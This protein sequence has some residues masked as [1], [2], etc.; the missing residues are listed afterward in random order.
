METLRQRAVTISDDDLAGHVHVLGQSGM[1]KSTLIEQIALQRAWQGRGFCFIDPHGQSAEHILDRIPPVR[2]K[3]ILY[4]N[5]ANDAY[6]VGLNILEKPKNPNDRGVVASEV[7]RMFHG[8]FADSWG[9]RLEQVLRNT[10][11]ALLEQEQATLLSIRRMLVNEPYRQHVLRRVRNH[12]VL[13]YWR[14]EFGQYSERMIPEVIGSTLNKI[15]PFIADDRMRRIVGQPH[16]KYDYKRG[17]ESQQIIIANLSKSRIGTEQSKYLGSMLITKLV[18]EARKRA[19]HEARENVFPLFVDEVQNFGTNVLTELVTEARKSG[20]ALVASHQ[21]LD[22]FDHNT[23]HLKKA[24]MGGTQTKVLF[25]LGISDAETYAAFL[26]TGRPQSDWS[27]SDLQ[28]LGQRNAVLKCEGRAVGFG[29]GGCQAAVSR[30][31]RT[32][33]E[34]ESNSTYGKR[35]HEVEAALDRFYQGR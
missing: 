3:D 8:L 18:I 15:D 5:P 7:M 9:V 16:G 33:V 31:R 13:E 12:V 2:T 14:D 23:E 32:V 20:L 6:S 17:M 25:Q 30:G 10:I 35:S 1:G 19:E 26:S 28:N 24:L 34:R 11:L 27:A 29:T 21:Y 22:Q 4:I